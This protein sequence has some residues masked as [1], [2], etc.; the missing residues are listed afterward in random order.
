VISDIWQ[1]LDELLTPGREILL[2]SEAG[3]VVRMLEEWDETRAAAMGAVARAKVLGAH[4]AAHR[5][6]ELEGWLH[7]AMAKQATPL[8]LVSGA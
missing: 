4:S 1:G 7:E 2:A 6:A 5:A 3:Q 8:R